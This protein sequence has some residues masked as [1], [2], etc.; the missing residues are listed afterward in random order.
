MKRARTRAFV[1][2]VAIGVAHEASANPP[3][4]KVLPDPPISA[5]TVDEAP[6]VVRKHE[7]VCYAFYPSGGTLAVE[8]PKELEL[9]PLGEAILKNAAGKCQ[10]VPFAAGLP[11]KKGPLAKCPA[12]LSV[13]AK[14]NVVPESSS[15]LIEKAMA[16]RTLEA[17]DPDDEEQTYVAPPPP[18]R[19]E[20]TPPQQVGCALSASSAGGEVAA[21]AS[22]A[23]VAAFAA[24][25]RKRRRRN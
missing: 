9:E 17:A 16:E 1:S 3:P 8:C 19:L 15:K 11:G 4:P 2:V 18:A 25:R 14:A 21:A 7:G 12:V 23:L 5:P 6:T 24:H 22:I 13:V 20:S 10:Y